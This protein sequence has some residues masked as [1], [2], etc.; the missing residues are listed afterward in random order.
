VGMGG[1]CAGAVEPTRGAVES[2]DLRGDSMYVCGQHYGMV[3]AAC[4]S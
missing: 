2:V 4:R 1:C 3:E